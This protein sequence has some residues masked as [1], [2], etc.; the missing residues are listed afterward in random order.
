ML[1]WE[2]CAD[3]TAIKLYF[4]LF[5]NFKRKVTFLLLTTKFK[6]R[7]V[8]CV[9]IWKIFTNEINEIEDVINT[10]LKEY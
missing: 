1:L 5:F 4:I 6:R 7:K 9:R 3:S 2:V 8:G 10:V